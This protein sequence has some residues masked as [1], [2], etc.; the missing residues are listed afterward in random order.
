VKG[1]KRHL[2][3]EAD[4]LILDI[5]VMPADSSNR[6]AAITVFR[7][8]RD[9]YPRVTSMWADRGYTGERVRAAATAAGVRVEIVTWP[10]RRTVWTP[11]GVEPPPWPTGVR[12]MKRRWIVKRTFVW[13][14]NQRRLGKEY[15]ALTSTSEAWIDLT[16]IR[17]L[18]ARLAR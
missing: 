2:V 11:V 1:R 16:M 14:G 13:L 5:W 18:V 8:L 17:F 4:G 12:V 10:E 7:T 9:R 6:D 15:D 3:V